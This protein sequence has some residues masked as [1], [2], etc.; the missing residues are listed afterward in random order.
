[1]KKIEKIEACP[2]CGEVANMRS[3]AN[4][5]EFWMECGDGECAGMGPV[6]K[7]NTKAIADWNRREASKHEALTPER[8]G[9]I[10]GAARA[11]GLL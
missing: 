9:R 3:D 11:Q 2:F 5:T 4:E 10:V 8:I 7:S 1:M 6:R